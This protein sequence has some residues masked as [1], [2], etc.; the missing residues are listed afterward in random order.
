MEKTKLTPVRF[1]VELLSDLDSHVGEG[2]R[3]KFIVEATKKELTRLKQ[4]KALK[5]AQGIF[6]E[7]I[8]PEFRTAEEVS[9]WV[10]KLRE[11]SE[12]RRRE[13]FSED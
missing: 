4:R 10:R 1:P 13:L 7:D 2:R 12:V 6:K 8:Y 9:E 3:S 5:S 11:E